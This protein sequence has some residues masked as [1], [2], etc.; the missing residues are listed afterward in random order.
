MLKQ[1]HCRYI[2]NKLLHL[3]ITTVCATIILGT[4]HLRRT[5]TRTADWAQP[6]PPSEGR[7]ECRVG[8]EREV[9]RKRKMR[10][11]I[12]SLREEE[13][14]S[15]LSRKDP[16]GS[17]IGDDGSQEGPSISSGPNRELIKAMAVLFQVESESL[18]LRI[19]IISCCRVQQRSEL[20]QGTCKNQMKS[21]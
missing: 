15:S 5:R 18:L 2:L 1:Q 4:A 19:R 11:A 16:R 17:A 6:S 9:A 21:S 20:P 10:G 14:S 12:Q 8:R 3:T 7:E 13:T